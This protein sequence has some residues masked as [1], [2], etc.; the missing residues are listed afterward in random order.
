[1]NS[2]S[3]RQLNSSNPSVNASKVH[4]GS[5]AVNAKQSDMWA[6]NIHIT[7]DHMDPEDALT[8]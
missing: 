4:K 3:G 2:N 8:L 1:M 6:D 7:Q 5:T